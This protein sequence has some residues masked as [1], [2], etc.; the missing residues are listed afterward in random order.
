[1]QVAGMGCTLPN[2]C[3]LQLNHSTGIC[4][5]QGF[6]TADENLWASFSGHEGNPS[7][8]GS[9]PLVS[10]KANTVSACCASGELTGIS[11]A[12]PRVDLRSQQGYLH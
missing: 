11:S 5:V 6:G 4:K 10:D 7:D 3:H 2:L 1:M 9:L 8:G 12:A